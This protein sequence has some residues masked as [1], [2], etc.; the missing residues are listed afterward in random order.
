[1]KIKTDFVTNSSS[2][3][4][5]VVIPPNFET[6]KEEL[7]SLLDWEL[8][9]EEEGEESYFFESTLDGIDSLKNG[10]TVNPEDINENS[11]YALKN[12]LIKKGIIIAQI[13]SGE[14]GVDSMTGVK[15]EVI[16]KTFLSICNLQEIKELIDR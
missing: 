4:Y 12:L 7:E 16:E 3:A 14:K 15:P 13:E 1:M 9:N 10:F 11:F 6:T 5:I 2:T 8:D